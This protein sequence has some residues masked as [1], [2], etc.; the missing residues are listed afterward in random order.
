MSYKSYTASPVSIIFISRLTL[1]VG[2]LELPLKLVWLSSFFLIIGGGG[3]VTSAVAMMIITDATN[4][5]CRSVS[6][7]RNLANDVECLQD[8]QIRSKIFFYGQACL[9]VA[10][11]TGPALGT[12]LMAKSLWLP[13]V[14]GLSKLLNFHL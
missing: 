13:L 9:I 8:R 5:K 12:A 11:Y 6:Q 4:E 1:P 2:R 7:N 14:L 3:T 10:E